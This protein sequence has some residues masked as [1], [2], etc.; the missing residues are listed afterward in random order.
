[1]SA[2][3]DAPLHLTETD[4]W[5]HQSIRRTWDTIV[6]GE[7]IECLEGIERLGRREGMSRASGEIDGDSM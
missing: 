6:P 7:P 1:M 4:F 2:S 3:Q 5:K